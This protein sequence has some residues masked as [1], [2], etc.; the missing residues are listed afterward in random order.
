MNARKPAA[1]LAAFALSIGMTTAVAAA[2]PVSYGVITCDALG[3][4]AREM[5]GPGWWA[6][7]DIARSKR[8]EPAMDSCAG[9]SIKLIELTPPA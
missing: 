2:P 1:A 9:G 8:T 5:S 7:R 4:V 6:K 3:E